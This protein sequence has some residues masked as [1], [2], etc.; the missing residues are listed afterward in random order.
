MVPNESFDVSKSVC[1]E[2]SERSPV[3]TVAPH[4]SI[5]WSTEITLLTVGYF[6]VGVVVEERLKGVNTGKRW[7]SN[8]CYVESLTDV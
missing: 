7:I 6:G 2:G 3:L 8:V 4:E 5:S 1:F